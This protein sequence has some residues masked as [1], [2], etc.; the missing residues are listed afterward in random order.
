M[1]KHRETLH[2]FLAHDAVGVLHYIQEV[3][4]LGIVVDQSTEPLQTFSQLRILDLGDGLLILE[5]LSK[6]VRLQLMSTALLKF[7]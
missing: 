1:F 7:P 4:I 6:L 5:L 3:A 2:G